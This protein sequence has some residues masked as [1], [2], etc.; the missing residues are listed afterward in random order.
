MNKPHLDALETGFLQLSFA[1][2]LWHYLDQHPIN[3]D[4]FDIALTVEDA[5]NRVC[6]PHN[7]FHSY[8]EIKIAS[9]NN[10]SI[11]FGATALTLWEA[12]NETLQY[13]KTNP[14]PMTTKK[15]KL[16]GLSYMIRC[17]FAHGTAIPRWDINSK[18]Q[19]TYTVGNKII[20]LTSL[21]GQPFDY[22]H[23]DGYETLWVIRSEASVLG[24]L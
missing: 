18:Y 6:L 13:S 20:D 14:N 4:Q 3:K 15:E 19:K 2:K 12:L 22:S 10:I 17:C 7:E 16:A 1:I 5:K 11:C 24:M 23:I 21:H 9:E 8:E